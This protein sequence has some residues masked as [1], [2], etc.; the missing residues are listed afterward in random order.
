MTEEFDTT[1]TTDDVRTALAEVDEAFVPETTIYQK[2]GDAEFDVN[3]QLENYGIDTHEVKQKA[4]DLCVR[5]VAARQ[6]WNSTPAEVRR[7]ALDTVRSYDLQEM[8]HQLRRNEEEAWERLGIPADDGTSAAFV[9]VTTHLG[10]QPR[11]RRRGGRF[12]P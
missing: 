3:F 5:A 7:Q 12:G 11:K 8:R 1:V 10:D 4:F 9:D 2:I 6:A